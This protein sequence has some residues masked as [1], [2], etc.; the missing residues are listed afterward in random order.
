VPAGTIAGQS[1]SCDAGGGAPGW[2]HALVVR[3]LAG[4]IVSNE[5]RCVALDPDGG[6]GAPPALPPVPAVGEIWRAALRRIEAPRVGVSPVPLGLTG[7][8]TWLWYDGPDELAVSA[9]IG[10][11]TVTGTA[12]LS[13]VTFDTGDGQVVTTGTPGSATA[14]AASHVYETKGTY[15][16]EITA[17]WTAEFVL[18]GPGLPARPT[19][20]GSAV[21]RASL[22]YGVQEIRALLVPDP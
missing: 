12:R 11:W 21:L 5:P 22:D 3:D 14:P 10:P 15:R 16:I 4:A 7:L 18:S 19:P 1:P 17:R 13:E 2:L 6:I 9:S 20:M 8:E